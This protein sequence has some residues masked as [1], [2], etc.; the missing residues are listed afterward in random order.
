MSGIE[1]FVREMIFC[2]ICSEN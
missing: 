1:N 2:S